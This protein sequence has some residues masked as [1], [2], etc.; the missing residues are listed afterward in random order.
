MA[1]GLDNEIEGR[2]GLPAARVVQVI[3]RPRRAPI[4]E[5]LLEATGSDVRQRDVLRDVSEPEAVHCGIEDLE[6]AVEHELSF[7]PDGQFLSITLELP[8]VKPTIGGQAQVDAGVI[9]E[10]LRG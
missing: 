5:R 3:P 1:Q 10:V 4:L 6:D 2:G 7:D 9:D 8:S